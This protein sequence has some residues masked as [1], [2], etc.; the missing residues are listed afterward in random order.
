MGPRPAQTLDT[1]GLKETP[2]EGRGSS[3]VMGGRGQGSHARLSS[4]QNHSSGISRFHW[5]GLVAATG[6][7]DTPRAGLTL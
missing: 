6:R 2:Q 1:E 3:P 5:E 4:F 7:R